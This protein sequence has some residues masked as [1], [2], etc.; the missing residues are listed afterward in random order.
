MYVSTYHHPREKN[1][2]NFLV[3]LTYGNHRLNSHIASR[4]SLIK[5]R[6]LPAHTSISELAGN[7]FING[8]ELSRTPWVNPRCNP[9][10]ELVGRQ[11]KLPAAAELPSWV[12]RNV[13]D[14]V[15]VNIECKSDRYKSNVRALWKDRALGPSPS[16]S[17]KPAAKLTSTDF[18]RASKRESYPLEFG[19]VLLME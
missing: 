11:L 8:S 12:A 13:D 1:K 16:F 4:P 6:P 17:P 5:W 7:L 9:M 2:S 3:I 18:P 15:D 19:L 14:S 10:D